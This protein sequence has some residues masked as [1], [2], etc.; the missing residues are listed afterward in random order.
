MPILKGFKKH[1]I[2]SFYFSILCGKHF[3]GEHIAL[4]N[5]NIRKQIAIK[6]ENLKIKLQKIEQILLEEF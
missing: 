3:I 2:F 1:N 5:E 6:N 4:G